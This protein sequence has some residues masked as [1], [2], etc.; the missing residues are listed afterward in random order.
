MKYLV[1]FLGAA[2]V[3]LVT[4]LFSTFLILWVTSFVDSGELASE[5]AS[6]QLY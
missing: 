1:C 4:I 6:K 3:R 5:E 2:L